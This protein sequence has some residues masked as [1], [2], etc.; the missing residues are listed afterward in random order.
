MNSNT[1]RLLAG[2]LGLLLSASV[3]A[4]SETVLKDFSGQ[5]ASIEA[6]AGKGYGMDP[7]A[8]VEPSCLEWPSSFWRE[9]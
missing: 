9:R 4:G 2:L 7:D 8:E 5:P 6:Y 3:F 1:R